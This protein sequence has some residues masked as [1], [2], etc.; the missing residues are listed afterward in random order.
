M[1]LYNPGDIPQTSQSVNIGQFGPSHDSLQDWRSV[2]QVAN[3]MD[4]ILEDVTEVQGEI[5][6]LKDQTTTLVIDANN[7]VST[8]N[9]INA[10][11]ISN[12]EVKWQQINAA[13]QEVESDRAE[14]DSNTHIALDAAN[15]S[16]QEA[17]KSSSS[18]S[19]AIN[20]ANKAETISN[21]I[22]QVK[23]TGYSLAE[24]TEAT[25]SFDP[26]TNTIRIGIPTR[27]ADVPGKVQIWHDGKF[28]ADGQV[29]LTAAD[30]GAVPNVGDIKFND[31]V[32]F[33]ADGTNEFE[34]DGKMYSSDPQFTILHN[35]TERKGLVIDKD[36]NGA[37]G[38]ELYVKNLVS[39]D[40]KKVFHEGNPPTAAQVGA[41]AK[42]ETL[43][44]SDIIA[45]YRRKDDSYSRTEIDNKV[46]AKLSTNPQDGTIY[47]R[48]NN[49]WV[50]VGSSI[51]SKA[52]Q[53]ELDAAITRITALENKPSYSG[54]TKVWDGSSKNIPWSSITGGSRYGKYTIYV[55]TTSTSYTAV[56]VWLG[57]RANN[58]YTGSTS[59]YV[60][61]TTSGIANLSSAPINIKSI[62]WEP[63]P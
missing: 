22:Q 57:L 7:A 16:Q 8:A 63:L 49:N 11:T 45:N 58:Y 13:Q 40:K 34:L 51:D 5:N 1:A 60:D 37:F 46:N 59:N 4:N 43:S 23:A 38:G 55:S 35:G 61:I 39:A 29:K 52:A 19:D 56:V 28:V 15:H 20:A 50:D 36:G 54:P 42:S 21:S 14:V 53:T 18:A 12:V 30:V 27:L 31:K 9:Q 33:P 24:G 25:A 6:T 10:D 32:S 41:F 47:S 2:F 26:T 3:K 48:K 17:S 62:W 44:K